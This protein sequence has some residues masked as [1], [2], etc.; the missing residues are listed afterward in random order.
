MPDKGLKNSIY[1]HNMAALSKRYPDLADKIDKLIEDGSYKIV[2]SERKALPNLLFEHHHAL[3][4]YYDN[5]DP[6]TYCINYINSLRL[7]NTPIIFFFG[8]GLGY[9][10]AYFFQ[11]MVDSLKVNSA[12]IVEKDLRIFKKAL[13]AVDLSPYILS[14]DIKFYVG[15]ELYEISA[16]FD[17]KIREKNL[18][19][20]LKT[21]KFIVM[22]AGHLLHG[23]YYA[24]LINAINDTCD[25]IL[26][27]VGNDPY[28]GLLG[29]Q[30]TFTN[31]SEILKNPGINMLY[32]K[33][34][35]RPGIVIAT[36]PSLKK[37][38]HLLKDLY[39]RALL[40]S[41]DASLKVLMDE[42]IKP[43]LVASLERTPGIDNLV[44]GIKGLDDVYY[45]TYDAV[46]PETLKAYN[47]PKI[48]VHRNYAY[49]DW[50]GIDKGKL[51]VGPSTANMA[52]KIAETLGCNPIILIG[53]D[54][55]LGKDGYT[56]AQGA[57]T[58]ET[59]EKHRWPFFEIPGNDGNP[60]KTTQVWYDMLKF[61]EYDISNYKGTCI[62][63]TEGGAKINGAKKM[64]LRDVI[65]PYCKESF[66]PINIIQ[67]ALSCFSTSDMAT[68]LRSISKKIN[69][70]MDITAQLI[71]ICKDG[72]KLIEEF[73]RKI[74]DPL[75]AGKK[76]PLEDKA[77]IDR[78]SK[79]ILGLMTKI[80]NEPFINGMM[81]NILQ[82]YHFPFEIEKYHLPDQFESPGIAQ[83]Q[84]IHRTK[85]WF[86]TIGQLI[87]SNKQYLLQGKQHIDTVLEKEHLI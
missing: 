4:A 45:T 43:H 77:L 81:A 39:D 37:N 40:I 1:D 35:K 62:N 72:I 23:K 27:I 83:V 13:E 6:L 85:E 75:L 16:D 29:L 31:I 28:D 56:H 33:F 10:L 69:N 87:L 24:E 55:S 46:T 20:F 18:S 38:M 50:M 64:K 3:C 32:G 65:D 7:K 63:A 51:L 25:R 70:S 47:G 36:G 42:G 80:A 15:M 84:S 71:N 60:V 78:Y 8:I 12:I 67:N 2:L 5:A 30:N 21:F 66:Y 68:E 9:Q 52:F 54:L 82:S 14:P 19:T 57:L 53:Q 11:H 17:S 22:P 34:R 73:D 74:Y 49:Y 58:N 79:D 44:E 61:Y 48:F 59:M 86:S 76:E 26:S 41:V